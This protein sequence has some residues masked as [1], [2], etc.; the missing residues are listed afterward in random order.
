MDRNNRSD[1]EVKNKEVDM[2]REEKRRRKGREGV[3]Q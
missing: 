1:L 2:R 3:V